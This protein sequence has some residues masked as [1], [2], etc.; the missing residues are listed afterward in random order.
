MSKN[1]VYIFLDEINSVAY[2]DEEIEAK[3]WYTASI[4]SYYH[5]ATRLKSS[6]YSEQVDVNEANFG[7]WFLFQHISPCLTIKI[8]YSIDSI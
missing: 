6:N 3:G 2:L 7:T 5:V 4:S 8:F 1:T